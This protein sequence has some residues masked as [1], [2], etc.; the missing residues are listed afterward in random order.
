MATADQHGLKASVIDAP[1]EL[2]H[3][4]ATAYS[5]LLVIAMRAAKQAQYTGRLPYAAWK[6]AVNARV[7]PKRSEVPVRIPSIPPS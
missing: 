2:L 1:G 7:R 5:Q 6:V 4:A 3:F